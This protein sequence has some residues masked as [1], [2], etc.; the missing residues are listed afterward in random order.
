MLT[1]S[2]AVIPGMKR[3]KVSDHLFGCT[4]I[5]L[6]ILWL[7]C[8]NP[9]EQG[10]W[11]T[12]CENFSSGT[13]DLKKQDSNFVLT[14]L[15]SGKKDPQ[16][17]AYIDA[18]PGYL[19]N[20]VKSSSLLQLQVIIFHDGLSKSTSAFLRQFPHIKA[21]KTVVPRH[22]SPNDFRFLLYLQWMKKSARSINFILVADISDVVFFANPF[23]HMEDSFKANK[24]FFPSSDVGS[25]ETNK[26][27]GELAEQCFPE[28]RLSETHGHLE[29]LNA[30][31]WGGESSVVACL[32]GCV[33][34]Y[35]LTAIPG[36]NCNMIA[37]NICAHRAYFSE[38]TNH[39]IDDY[40]LYNSFADRDSC[41]SEYKVI[42]DKCVDN[43][44]WLDK[45]VRLAVES[46]NLSRHGR[47]DEKTGIF[48]PALHKEHNLPSDKDD[49]GEN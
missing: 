26:Y 7:F 24:I 32:L 3:P 28:A 11:D 45:K 19:N 23:S 31:L 2:Q 1:K 16:R 12:L 21:I 33:K 8:F 36:V 34:Q 42:H 18:S 35:L 14:T 41:T 37:Y 46:G 25:L 9:T 22:L 20:F 17:S 4:T 15:F 6:I 38:V 49:K 39:V 47:L 13:P 27:I 44:F 43:V 10:S 48:V 40:Q 29:V 30:G 5:L